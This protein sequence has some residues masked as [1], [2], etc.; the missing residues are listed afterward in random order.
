MGESS[1]VVVLVVGLS[2]P[3]GKTGMDGPKNYHLKIAAYE[4]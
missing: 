2:E 1:A 4:K 3:F